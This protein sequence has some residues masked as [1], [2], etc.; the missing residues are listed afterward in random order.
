MYFSLPLPDL[1]SPQKQLLYGF[2]CVCKWTN[3]SANR[4]SS[5]AQSIRTFKKEKEGEKKKKL[6]IE[7]VAAEPGRTSVSVFRKKEGKKKIYCF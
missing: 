7:R 3:M 2:G 4:C 1:K 6:F 5:A